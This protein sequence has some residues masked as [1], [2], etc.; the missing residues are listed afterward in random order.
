MDWDECIR[1]AEL[2]GCG[3]L[4]KHTLLLSEEVL[5]AQSPAHIKRYVDD[6]RARVLAKT[7]RT[8][9]LQRRRSEL[10][11]EFARRLMAR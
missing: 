8:F 11:L 9:L 1:L 2:T 5:G 3:L 4:L 6:E 10:P 7:A